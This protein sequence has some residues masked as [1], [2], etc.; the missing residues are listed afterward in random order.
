MQP[1]GPRVLAKPFPKDETTVTGFIVPESYR[2]DSN[3]LTVVSVGPGSRKNPMRFKP[4]DVVFRIK[5][6]GQVVLVEGETMFIIF[7]DDLIATEN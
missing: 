5:D 3:K 6:A 1:A 7:Q 2:E 4:N